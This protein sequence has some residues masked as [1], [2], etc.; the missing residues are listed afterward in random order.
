MAPEWKF[1][2]AGDPILPTAFTAQLTPN[3]IGQLIPLPNSGDAF[4]D[5]LLGYPV[6]GVLGGLPV[7]QYRGTVRSVLS[8]QLED[9]DVI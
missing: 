2:S 7:V 8:G 9:Q 1:A 3:S 5:F 6:T 4:A